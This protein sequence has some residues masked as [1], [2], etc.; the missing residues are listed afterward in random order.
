MKNLKQKGFIVPVLLVVIALLVI[1]GGVYIYKNK[2][3]EVPA[4]VDNGT[5]QTNTQTQPVNTKTNT[6]KTDVNF[7]VSGN[8]LSVINNG[9]VTQTLSLGE[10]GIFALNVVS[11]NNPSA[12]ITDKDV[13]FDG[14]ND[15]G[16]LTSTG[17]AGVN[18]FYD[19]YIFNPTTQKL[20]KSAVLSDFVLT[21]I[22]PIKKQIISTY[23]SGPGYV[24]YIYQWNGSTFIKSESVANIS[25]WKT[26]TNTQYGFSIQYQNDAQ[27]TN[28]NRNEGKEFSF[29]FPSKK[30]LLVDIGTQDTFRATP[31]QDQC[32]KKN[33]VQVNINGV[34]FYSG[35]V[36]M[37]Y[38]GMSAGNYATQYCTI[39]NGVHYKLISLI[40]YDST[41]S[42]PDISNP[43][44]KD[45]ILEQM[46][47][48]FKFNQ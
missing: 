10:G 23:K 3:V 24:S 43:N 1:G 28:T 29:Y 34:S 17:Y 36:S 40:P 42:N 14:H 5:Q 38:S 18:Y 44:R 15:V 2:K 11:G 45:T 37:E 47:A 19:F 25:N 7:S 22:D 4:V 33:G 39:K 13:N 12:F 48:S 8:N 6:S 9:K 27:V 20:E 16:V 30:G 21:S 41:S 26:Y 32:D 46:I 35:D 31:T